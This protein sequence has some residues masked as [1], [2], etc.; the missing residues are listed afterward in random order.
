MVVHRRRRVSDDWPFIGRGEEIRRISQVFAGDAAAGVVLVGPPGA[1][2]T[3][4]AREARTVAA[5]ADLGVVWISGTRGCS[6]VPFGV[7]DDELLPPITHRRPVGNPIAEAAALL[8]ARSGRRGLAVIADDAHL[9]DESTAALLFQLALRGTAYVLATFR[10]GEPVPEPVS[11]LWKDGL[12]SRVDLRG[13]DMESIDELLGLVLGAQVDTAATAHLAARATGSILL[14]RELVV[15]AVDGGSL[16]R[17]G[18]VW[19]L[20]GP[21]EPSERLVELVEGRLVDLDQD[22]RALMELVAYAGSLGAAELEAIARPDVLERLE[23]R[24]LICVRSK[25]VRVEARLTQPVYGDVIR[26]RLPGMAVRNIARRLADALEATGVRPEDDPRLGMWRLDGGAWTPEQLLPAAVNARW[27]YQFQLADRLVKTA[28][29]AAGDFEAKLLQSQL[30][31]LQ[32][33]AEDAEK[34]L[35]E[36]WPQ[37]RDD[38]ERASVAIR[39]LDNLVFFLGRN[40]EGLRV[41]DEAEMAI[42][43]PKWRHEIIARR[44][45][46]R[47]TTHGFAAAAEDAV[48]LLASAEGPALLWACQI[49]AF[50]LA[51]TGKIQAALDATARGTEAAPHI[52]GYDWYSWMLLWVRCET[53]AHAGRFAEAHELAK[54]QYAL[55]LHEGS[56]E[57][58][59]YFAFELSR[60]VLDRGHVVDAVHDAREAVALLR[61]LGRPAF[62]RIALVHL[63]TALAVGGRAD[64][65]REALADLDALDLEPAQWILVELGVARGWVAVAMGDLRQAHEHF[66]DAARLAEAAN[67]FVGASI[68]LHSLA[69]SGPAKRVAGRLAGIAAKAEGE[70]VAARAA[71]AEALAAADA[72]ALLS[73]AADFEKIG[74]TLLAAEATADAAVV[75]RAAGEPLKSLSAERWSASL[76]RQCPAAPT[77]ALRL[78]NTRALLTP[79]EQETVLLAARGQ[80]NREIAETLFLSVRTVENRLQRAYEKL[81]VSKRSQLADLVDLAP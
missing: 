3:R 51:R 34:R 12:A 7:L 35:A 39:R 22:E 41:A 49:A 13:L 30:D 24:G 48:P 38:E 1:G 40:Q 73:V 19:R 23:R 10:S 56:D 15:S 68:A 8:R 55:G 60:G 11:A 14:L 78:G 6:N 32:G 33:R 43:D 72:D 58:R 64:E 42:A 76:V 81:G 75:F 2:R 80:S 52:Q 5:G 50:G 67:D 21:I 29:D 36:L 74:A 59:A 9:L 57:A 63:S 45:G 69:R 28:L 44:A 79:A 53:L 66:E 70:L 65:A 37:A 27:H 4:V 62:V 17:E 61:K 25:D 16:T 71:H 31:S 18:D 20:S 26:S 77:P 46:I 54:A 47:L